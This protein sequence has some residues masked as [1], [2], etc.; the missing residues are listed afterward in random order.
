NQFYR[1]EADE[2]TYPFHVLIRYKIEKMLFNKEIKVSEISD[3]FNNLFFE[4]FGTKPS[5]KSEGCYQDVHWS[6]GFAYFPTYVLGSAISA[7]ILNSMEKDFNP[8]LDMKK[9]EFMRVNEWLKEHV[10]K[11]GASKTNK[12]VIKLAT[13]EEFNPKYYIDY[14]KDKF[15]KI[16]NL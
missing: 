3:T 2:L 16:Y 8:F 13:N 1:T 5:N 4:Y 9:G 6:S 14:L 7:Q 10:H 11:Y 15:S 12:E